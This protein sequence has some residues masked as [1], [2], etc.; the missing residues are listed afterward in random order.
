MD[1]KEKVMAYAN[2]IQIFSSEEDE[3]N[4]VLDTKIQNSMHKPEELAFWTE[5]RGRIHRRAMYHEILEMIQL[6]KK[7]LGNVEQFPNVATVTR[8]P[9]LLKWLS[10]LPNFEEEVYFLLDYQKDNFIVEKGN[11]QQHFN[12]TLGCLQFFNDAIEA[13]K[14]LEELFNY[15]P[16]VTWSIESL[17]VTKEFHDDFQ[18]F[19]LDT[20]VPLLRA[21]KAVVLI[22][23]DLVNNEETYI[24]EEKKSKSA[25]SQ[26][27]IFTRDYVPHSLNLSIPAD[28]KES[29][30]DAEDPYLDALSFGLRFMFDKG[31]LTGP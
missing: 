13:N 22:F 4:Q 26:S 14:S 29:N 30:P 23:L 17:L 12:S 6:E 20:F 8:S 25:I 18:S 7:H 19:L 3:L 11:S 31:S 16:L 5:V 2:V 28:P 9:N 24:E 27:S 1:Y 10:F 21:H 15:I